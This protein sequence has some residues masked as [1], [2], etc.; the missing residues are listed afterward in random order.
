MAVEGD[1]EATCRSEGGGRSSRVWWQT[2]I[3]IDATRPALRLTRSRVA[4]HTLPPITLR[5]CFFDYKRE[6]KFAGV[7]FQPTRSIIQICPSCHVHLEEPSSSLTT[8]H[9]CQTIVSSTSK[10]PSSP[11]IP[12][13]VSSRLPDLS[14]ATM[15]SGSST[16][17]SKTADESKINSPRTPS[18]IVCDPNLTSH[19]LHLYLPRQ[20]K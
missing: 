2:K 16:A 8:A 7:Q 17:V 10:H 13:K 6:L 11:T 3:V 19:H 14:I 4:T 12:T 9:L 20:L 1:A 5:I 15:M 18:S